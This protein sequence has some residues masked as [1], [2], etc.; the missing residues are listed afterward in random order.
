M[1]VP[2]SLQ[3]TRRRVACWRLQRMGFSARLFIMPEAGRG[4]VLLTNQRPSDDELAGGA[5]TC[6]DVRYVGHDLPSAARPL[7]AL[8]LQ[9]RGPPAPWCGCGSTR[10]RVRPPLMSRRPASRGR[11]W[12]GL[13]IRR[14]SPAIRARVVGRPADGSAWPS[15]SCWLS[16]SV[17]S[18]PAPARAMTPTRS[19]GP[20]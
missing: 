14:S 15:R 11:W 5:T 10:G 6:P 16:P 7:G 9:T 13:R 18:G 20:L 1:D 17:P 12:T 19:A 4:T 8:R 3:V 2:S